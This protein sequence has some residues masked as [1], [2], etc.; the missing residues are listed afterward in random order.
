M[1][2]CVLYHKGLLILHYLRVCVGRHMQWC[3]CGHQ[4]TVYGNHIFPSTTRIPGIELRRNTSNSI[5]SCVYDSWCPL[6]FW[7]PHIWNNTW[8]MSWFTFISNTTSKAHWGKMWAW[9]QA[10]LPIEIPGWPGMRGVSLCS[11][12][13]PWNLDPYVSRVLV[14]E[15]G[16]RQPS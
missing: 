1:H 4:R 13:Q 3:W 8:I 12:R 11:P 5:L 7:F 10:P 2:V 6:K 9:Q 16:P 14:A 15:L